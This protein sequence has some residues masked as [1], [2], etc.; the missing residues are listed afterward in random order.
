MNTNKRNGCNAMEIWKDLVGH[1]QYMVS[2][3]G[4]IMRKD[5]GKIHV[6]SKTNRGYIRFDISENGKRFSIL[7]HRAV[8]LAFIPNI[9]GKKEVNH[10]DGDKTNNTVGNL[11]WCTPVEN[12]Q[13]A[14]RVLGREPVNKIPVICLE[15]GIVYESAY[16]A[17]RK[18]G[19]SNVQIN[20]CCTGKRKSTRNT[21]WRYAGLV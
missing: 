4:R 6:G 16:E 2:S 20:R 17:E 15:T 10:K 3:I 9:H 7:C 1:D 14:F 13:H 21:H 18:T 19:I 5:T 12:M 8:A 11:E